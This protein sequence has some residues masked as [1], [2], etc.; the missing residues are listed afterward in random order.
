MT[1][2]GCAGMADLGDDI[3][4]ALGVPVVDGVAAATQ[5]VESPVALGL[6]T[7]KRGELARP[8]AKPIVGLLK[9]FTL[10]P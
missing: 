7:S 2:L 9:G 5:L 6:R 10:A 4:Q 3:A 1:V 8:L